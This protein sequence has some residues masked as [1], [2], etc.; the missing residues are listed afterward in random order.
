[1]E[2]TLVFWDKD[3]PGFC[4]NADYS[5]L[6][7]VK[8]CNAK[9]LEKEI[10]EDYDVFINTHGSFFPEKAFNAILGF[11]GRGN[12]FINLFS[13][14]FKFPCVYNEESNTWDVTLEKMSYFRKLN[15]Q[16]VLDAEQKDV[17]EFIA[18]DTNNICSCLSEVLSFDEYTSNFIITPTKDKYIAKEWGSSGSLDAKIIPLI[19]GMNRIK[20]HLSSPVVLIENRAGKY[21]GGRWIFVNNSIE[22]N[23]DVEKWLSPMIDYVQKG[24]REIMVKPSMPLY[25]ENEKPVIKVQAEN[26]KQNCNWSVTLTCFK[27]GQKLIEEEVDLVGTKYSV[28]KNVTLDI[29]LTP[30]IYHVSTKFTSDDGETRNIEQGFCVLDKKVLSSYK[31]V[32]CGKDYLNINGNMEPIV[33]TTYMSSEVSRSFLHIP[34]V[35]NWLK[36]MLEMKEEGINWIRTG[37]WCSWRAYMLDDGHIDESILRAIDAYI[38]V[39]ATVG[40]Q[41]TFTFF[42]FVPEPFEGSHPYL[43]IR[44]LNAQKR[45]IT[46]IVS[47]H[48]ETTN[49]DWDLINEPFTTDHPSQVKSDNDTFEIVDFQKF[50]QNE[51]KNIESMRDKLGLCIS[52]MPS[53]DSVG[54]PNR[55]D[56]NFDVT[57]MGS[58]KNGLIW[59]DYKKYTVLMFRNWVVELRDAIKGVT[60]NHLVTV[61]QDEALKGQRPTPLLYGDLVDYNCQHTWWLLDQLVWDT[62]F[63]KYNNKPLVVQET[64]VMYTEMPN[65]KPRRN[66]GDIANLIQ[67]KYAYAYG[68]RCAGAIQW[69]WNTNYYLQSAN[70]SNIGAIRCD[71][72]RKPEFFVYRDFSKFFG[73]AKTKVTNIVNNQEIAV[74]FPFSNDFS[75]R[76]FIQYSTVQTTKILSYNLKYDFLG[77]SEFDLSPLWENKP[78]FIIVPSAHHFDEIAFK[79]IMNYVETTGATLFFTGPISLDE[80]F[81]T[82][83]YRSELFGSKGIESLASYEK[84]EFMDNVWELSFDN[85]FNTKAY[86]ESTASNIKTFKVGNGEVIWSGVPLEL[87]FET[88]KIAE[89]YAKVLEYKNINTEIEV[90]G[91]QVNS[92]FASKIQWEEANLFTLI[93][94]STESKEITIKDKKT[95]ISYRLTID[96]DDSFL[97]ITDMEGQIISVYKDKEINLMA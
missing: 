79:E 43:D 20:G 75:N 86:K 97:F 38:Q 33:G 93:N 66:E 10:K 16:S 50:L 8:I 91:N 96:G 31:K 9:E 29:D 39:A 46:N 63:T 74:I 71:G 70:E 7:G 77:V 80:N 6:K 1:M 62:R 61:G 51:Y 87:S 67:K 49:V 35:A 82:S 76:N 92:I 60:D 84:V 13:T 41:V 57:D 45:F 26:F 17:E 40:L 89:I 32:N 30:G 14:P 18:N 90:V 4:N 28:N 65:S 54:I 59:K 81:N 69:I 73:K 3:F 64:G 68:T 11:L 27:D 53:F 36:D 48:K 37:M 94:E 88:S 2:K 52:D 15:I 22:K 78:K 19:K 95:K 5:I 23:N 24:Y 58:E 44:S 83:L 21:T 47:R 34:N 56:I 12:G 55:D 42:T 72:S 25:Y 85:G